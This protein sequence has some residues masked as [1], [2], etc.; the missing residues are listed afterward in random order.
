MSNL[1]GFI[2]YD[3]KDTLLW[4]GALFVAVLVFIVSMYIHRDVASISLQVIVFI[5]C[6]TISFFG[7]L[8]LWVIFLWREKKHGL[9]E[10]W[11]G[12]FVPEEYRHFETELSDRVRGKRRKR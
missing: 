1:T 10:I 7:R 2:F 11:N 5:A 3:N 4:G 6:Q 8:L 12:V 9:S